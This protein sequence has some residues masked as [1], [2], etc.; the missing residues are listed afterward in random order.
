MALA[1]GQIAEMIGVAGTAS[2]DMWFMV[3]TKFT[4][5]IDSVHSTV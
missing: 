1:D 3:F 2:D 5:H 4:T